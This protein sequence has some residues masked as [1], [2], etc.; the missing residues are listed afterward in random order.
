MRLSQPRRADNVHAPRPVSA[1]V[2]SKVSNRD[3]CSATILSNGLPS[4]G[5]PGFR[6]RRGRQYLGSRPATLGLWAST[7]AQMSAPWLVL[8][9]LTGITQ[10]RAQ[11]AAV[12]GLVVT[13]SALV[14][15]FAMTYSPIEIPM[16]SFDR[17]TAGVVAVT[18]R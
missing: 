6:V 11:R 7:A 13:A 12:L 8:P 1:A 4:S 3:P 18:T 2:K 14:G 17:F 9:F 5:D 10:Q 16:W 15:Y